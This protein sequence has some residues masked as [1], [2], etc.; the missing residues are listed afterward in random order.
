VRRNR[1][2]ELAG[3]EILVAQ[4]VIFRSEQQRYLL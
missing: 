1:E 3:F 2:Q 4:A